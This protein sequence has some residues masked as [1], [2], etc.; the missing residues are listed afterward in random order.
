MKPRPSNLLRS[1][2][3]A[4]A[5]E[6]ALVVPV[7]IAFLLG[8]IDVGRLMWT[9]N[10]AEKATQM[11]VRFAVATDITPG[12]LATYSFVNN[13]GL[14]QGSPIPQDKFNGA[15]CTST[16][17][18]CS[19]AC[20]WFDNSKTNLGSFNNLVTRMK[21]LMPEI[22]AA[23]VRLDYAYSG[24]GYAGDPNGPDP[25]PLVTV[26]LT[27][28][29]PFQPILFSLWGG[30]ISLPDFSATLTMEDGQGSVSN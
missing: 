13:G 16:G 9:W 5:A 11:G 8:I 20:N 28:M 7:A 24:L 18:T 3:G 30:T 2:S 27:G 17:C 25:V 21:L 23:N 14:P 4:T 1:T 29:T 26:R 15:S 22:Q 6:F 12:G 19:S 10:R